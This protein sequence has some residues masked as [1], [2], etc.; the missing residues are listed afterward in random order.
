M[1]ESAFVGRK[2]S[3]WREQIQLQASAVQTPAAVLFAP[4]MIR[5]TKLPAE[6]VTLPVAVHD[7]FVVAEQESVVFAM[8]PGVPS[9][10]VTV[11]VPPC[12][13]KTFRVVAVQPAGTHVR[14]A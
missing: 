3:G 10:S 13:E 2:R 6:T 11:I 5:S 9:R 1:E 7:E 8:L 14:T 12:S 4:L